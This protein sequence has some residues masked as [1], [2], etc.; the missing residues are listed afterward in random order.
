MTQ[1]TSGYLQVVNDP[2]DNP[3]KTTEDNTLNKLE[4]QRVERMRQLKA[5]QYL[6]EKEAIRQ[7]DRTFR[8]EFLWYFAGCLLSA[9][10]GSMVTLAIMGVKL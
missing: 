5:E 9:G 1:H 3:L 2:D 10:I 6:A 7:R 8:A 4:D